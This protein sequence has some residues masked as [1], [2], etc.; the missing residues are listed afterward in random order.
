MMAIISVYVH[1]CN[2]FKC[3]GNSESG[4]KSVCKGLIEV[5]CRLG[6]GKRGPALCEY[7]GVG[8]SHASLERGS[9]Q[10]GEWDRPVTWGQ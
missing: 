2:T 5:L 1:F 4:K 6:G 9:G 10:G 3:K 8:E 7:Q